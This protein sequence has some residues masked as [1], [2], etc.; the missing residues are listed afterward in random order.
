MY[1][2]LLHTKLLITHMY[3]MFCRY[4]PQLILIILLEMIIIWPIFLVSLTSQSLRLH[5]FFFFYYL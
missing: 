3:I 4:F 2:L 1:K 5:Q